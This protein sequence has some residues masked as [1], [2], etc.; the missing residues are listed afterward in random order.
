MVI[1]TRRRPAWP[2]SWGFGLDTVFW[3]TA[4]PEAKENALKLASTR[5]AASQIMAMVTGLARRN[6]AAGAVKWG[7]LEQGVRFSAHAFRREIQP[8]DDPP[9]AR[10]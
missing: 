9:R 2:R 6:A 7:A 8:R 4:A 3:S 1:A 5:P 10:R